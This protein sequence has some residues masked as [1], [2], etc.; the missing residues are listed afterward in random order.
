MN[1]YLS[2]K[3]FRDGLEEAQARRSRLT[4]HLSSGSRVLE[5]GPGAGSF[6]SLVSASG[7]EVTAVE[8]E[9]EARRWIENSVGCSTVADL[10]EL[11]QQEQTF[12]LIVMFHVLEHLRD[13]IDIL[14]TDRKTVKLRRAID[15]RGP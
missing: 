14:A 6:L 7:H 5:I 2:I 3:E 9:L 1:T 12:N 11:E 4:P 8:P 10:G 13:P 15:Y